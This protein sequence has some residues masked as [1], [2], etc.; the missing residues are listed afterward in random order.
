M[1]QGMDDGVKLFRKGGTGILYLPAYLAYDAQAGPNH[2][3]YESLIFEIQVVDVTNAPI[4]QPKPKIP[5]Q[6]QLTP[7]QLQKLQQQAQKASGK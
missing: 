6:Q 7:E 4:E 5:M 1:I 2:K 3:P